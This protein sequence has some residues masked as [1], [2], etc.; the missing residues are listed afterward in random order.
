MSELGFQWRSPS[1]TT[2]FLRRRALSEI[3]SNAF[4]YYCVHVNY[5]MLANVQSKGQ[6]GITFQLS[7]WSPH[8]VQSVTY[9]EV[10]TNLEEPNSR[11]DI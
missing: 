1:S 4:H 3:L 5:K 10:T 8:M 6:E 11:L 9:N 7:T 2:Q